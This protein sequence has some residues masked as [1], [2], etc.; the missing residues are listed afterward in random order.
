MHGKWWRRNR[1][2]CAGAIVQ[3]LRR[4]RTSGGAGVRRSI[5]M[6]CMLWI[7]ESGVLVAL[8]ESSAIIPTAENQNSNYMFNVDSKIVFWCFK[9]SMLSCKCLLWQQKQ[10]LAPTKANIVGQIS[11]SFEDLAVCI[12]FPLQPRKEHHMPSCS[13]WPSYREYN[14]LLS[15][16]TTRKFILKTSFHSKQCWTLCYS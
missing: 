3:W 9:K 14:N 12:N 10:T 16:L 13:K 2:R 15:N 4:N 1:K 5:T 8:V 7:R 11:L 6:T